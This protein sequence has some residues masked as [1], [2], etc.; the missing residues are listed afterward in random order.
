[1]NETNHRSRRHEEG[2]LHEIRVR[3]LPRRALVGLGRWLTFTHAPDG[4]I[5]LVDELADQ[6]ALHGVLNRMRPRTTDQLSGG[7]TKGPVEDRVRARSC[8]DCRRDSPGWRPGLVKLPLRQSRGGRTYSG[9]PGRQAR[10]LSQPN[11]HADLRS[12]RERP[13]RVMAASRN[14]GREAKLVMASVVGQLPDALA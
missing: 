3:G 2:G 12:V 9:T 10:C 4:T 14:L 11:G 1:M 7:S 6:P 13:R 5:T 8:R